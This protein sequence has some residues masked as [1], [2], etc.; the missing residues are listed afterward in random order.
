MQTIE[1]SHF[2]VHGMETAKEITE[3]QKEFMAVEEA[4]KK[5][6]REAL[7]ADSQMDAEATQ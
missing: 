5:R 7:E 1:V 2:D 3:L 4:N 6:K